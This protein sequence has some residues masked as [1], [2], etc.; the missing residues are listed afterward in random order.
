[1]II[2]PAARLILISAFA[3]F[4]L[5]AYAQDN[6]PNIGSFSSIDGTARVRRQGSEGWLTADMTTSVAIEESIKT[7]E[8]S[9]AEIKTRFGLFRLGPLTEIKFARADMN[10]SVD[11]NIVSGHIW[12]VDNGPA[13]G[14][15]IAISSPVLLCRPVGAVCGFSV[16]VDGTTELKVYRGRIEVEGHPEK[17]IPEDSLETAAA[18]PENWTMTLQADQKL[19]VTSRGNIAFNGAFHPDDPDE[20]SP[21]IQWNLNRGQDS[22]A[23][24]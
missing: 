10:G 11:L 1:M 19:I 24:K 4:L 3:A 8:E 14:S 21:W 9:R 5:P 2:R 15:E 6:N 17:M 13:A 20:S 16:G 22:P 18:P 12:S 23:N 7:L